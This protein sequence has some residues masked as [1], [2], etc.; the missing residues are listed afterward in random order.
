LEQIERKQA[1][2]KEA[3]DATK[4][5]AD[6]AAGLADPAAT[7]TLGVHNCPRALVDRLAAV[8]KARSTG[9]QRVS[10]ASVAIE[11]IERGL[12]GMEAP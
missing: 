8:A 10:V 4:P 7:K 6:P 11:A 3:V 2:L 5:V 1:K 12:V 9:A